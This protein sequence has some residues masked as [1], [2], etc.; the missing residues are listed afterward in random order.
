MITSS[1]AEGTKPVLP[2]AIG[3]ANM[4]APMDVPA[5]KK[6]APMCLS[7]I[8]SNNLLYLV[9]RVVSTVVGKY[10]SL[11]GLLVLAFVLGQG[12]LFD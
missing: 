4:P 5:T 11:L 8:V 2:Q 7:V 12:I 6:V 3:S 10:A 9:E 1:A